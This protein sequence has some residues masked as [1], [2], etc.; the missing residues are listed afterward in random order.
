MKVLVSAADNDVL[1]FPSISRENVFYY[2][3]EGDIGA[4]GISKAICVERDID[5]D[6]YFA[7]IVETFFE[8]PTKRTVEAVE[9]LGEKLSELNDSLKKIRVGELVHIRKSKICRPSRC[10]K[11]QQLSHNAKSCN[12]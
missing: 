10:S 5:Q 9:M 11:C 4:R 6:S 12:F 7:S 8:D 3:R 2:L 1:V